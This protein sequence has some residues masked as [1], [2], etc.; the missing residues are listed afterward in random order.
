MQSTSCSNGQKLSVSL[1][2]RDLGACATTDLPC[3]LCGARGK[4]EW[5]GTFMEC[6][7]GRGC[8]RR[9]D[10]AVGI[11]GP[12]HVRGRI[13]YKVGETLYSVRDLCA[14]YDQDQDVF[15]ARLHMGW[16]AADALLT[17]RRPRPGRAPA[18]VEVGGELVPLAP[19]CEQAGV[20]LSTVRARLARGMP[21]ATA[22]LALSMKETRRMLRG[23]SPANSL[24]RVTKRR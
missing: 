17:P 9:E 3:R 5:F 22:L 24:P 23:V 6:S 16:T 8:K 10:E 2:R 1:S 18:C 7:V 14:A 15:R 19:L 4:R 13:H 20:K 11:E 12:F 21:L